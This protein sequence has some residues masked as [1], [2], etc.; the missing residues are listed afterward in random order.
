MYP[1]P[2]SRLQ[3]AAVAALEGVFRARVYLAISFF[4]KKRAAVRGFIFLLILLFLFLSYF[5]HL[6]LFL[7]CDLERARSTASIKQPWLITTLPLTRPFLA[8][9]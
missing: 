6:A 5:L 2:P 3:L 7:L 4:F 8:F 1:P 9:R